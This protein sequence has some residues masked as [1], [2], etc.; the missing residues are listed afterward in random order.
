MSR[1]RIA[2]L[3][4]VVALV[5]LG[6]VSSM[7]HGSGRKLSDEEV[8]ALLAQFDTF[9]VHAEGMKPFRVYVTKT[10]EKPVLLLHEIP[11]LTPETFALAQRLEKD[12]FRV[13]MPLLF[14]KPARRL[15]CLRLGLMLLHPA[16]NPFAKSEVSPRIRFAR[17]TIDAIAERNPARKIGVIGMCLTGNFGIP[18]LS[19]PRV[20]A[21]VLSQPAVPFLFKSALGVSDAD[22]AAARSSQ[23]KMFALRFERDKKSPVERWKR[24]EK[25]FPGQ[26]TLHQIPNEQPQ[27]TFPPNAH[28]VLTQW[29]DETKPDD[30]PTHVAYRA[31]SQFLRDNL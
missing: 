15:N 19:D 6:A 25:E 12:G 31:V 27:G 16:S 17:A 5:A 18:L 21:A 3:I 10:G 4:V 8:A 24:L 22:I 28:A 23:K 14:G 11:G 9:D 29:Y 20:G 30:Y 2:I 1:S 26:I 7:H 13:Y